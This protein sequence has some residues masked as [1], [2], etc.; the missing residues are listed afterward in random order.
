MKSCSSRCELRVVNDIQ[1]II[2]VGNNNSTCGILLKLSKKKIYGLFEE[3]IRGNICAAER[4]DFTILKPNLWNS[5]K[6]IEFHNY[7]TWYTGEN[8]EYA[9]G[10]E[11][12]ISTS[13][14]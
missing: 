7:Y 2:L 11:I 14:H 8:N 3:N 10:G 4:N 9:E 6:F 1:N 13:L 12:I 5:L